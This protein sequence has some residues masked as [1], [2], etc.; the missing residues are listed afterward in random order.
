MMM[1]SHAFKRM[2]EGIRKILNL[3]TA[4][5]LSSICGCL[6]LKTQQKAATSLELIM[7]Y[8]TEL[9]EL[10]EERTKRILG[11]MWEGALWEYLHSI[12]HPVHTMTL[13][14]KLTIMKIWEHGGF[15]E[16]IHS[17]IPHFIAREV[18][19]RND[20]VLSEDIQIRLD[21]IQSA[22]DQAK[23][24][25]R[26]IIS[27]HDYTNI[28][29][30][31][32][33]M[34][35]LRSL[36]NS[37]RE[38]LISELEIARS[39][40]DS[41]E[42]SSKI[43]RDQL[44]EM[45]IKF[46]KITDHLNQQLASY[47]S[48]YETEIRK[49]FSMETYLNRLS[50]MIDSY[51]ETETN[52]ELQGGGTLQPIKMRGI[53]DCP[54]NYIQE[55]H[56]KLQHYR[57]QRDEW[58]DTLRAQARKYVDHIHDL[59]EKLDH[60]QQRYD[61]LLEQYNH[62]CKDVDSLTK[63]HVLKERKHIKNEST[64]KYYAQYGWDIAL[65]SANMVNKYREEHLKIKPLLLAGVISTQPLLRN[66]CHTLL[67]SF[68]DLITTEEEKERISENMLM[69]DEDAYSRKAEAAEKERLYKL[70]LIQAATAKTPK[71]KAGGKTPKSKTPS[72]GKRPGSRGD[73]QTIKSKASDSSKNTKGKA[74][75]K[76]AARPASGKSSRPTSAASSSGKKTP[77]K[78]K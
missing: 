15:L 48:L 61:D 40:I 42:E 16:G 29:Q 32:N 23:L 68:H 66:I 52:R 24:A 72:G 78:K 18:K 53:Q 54:F 2:Q 75:G 1:K 59:E 4:V 9:E 43:I 20:W 21:K 46:I 55:I 11:F 25:E 56:M 8:A 71:A 60:L 17:F 38:Y 58:D 77:S 44:A 12:G 64:A 26:K 19:Q 69:N 10:D 50:L 62:A 28:L 39:R 13:D 30:Y 34:S 37:V 31:F 41:Y 65:K 36:E 76:T 47:E 73:D 35:N 57:N 5:E 45:E 7:K 74:K 6:Q 67:F 14:P 51:K 33:Q 27:D 70:S 49:N 63:D 3:H 22:Q